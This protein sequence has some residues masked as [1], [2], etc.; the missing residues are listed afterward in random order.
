M[1]PHVPAILLAAGRSR[2]MGCCKQL[3][4]L[5]DRPVIAHC[6]SSIIPAGIPEIIVVLGTRHE[7]LAAVVRDFPA[8]IVCNPDPEGDMSS[9]VQ[10]GMQALLFPATG[11]I[12]C[13]TDH[14]LVSPA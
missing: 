10:V 14:P 12:V 7:E 11:V 8:T 2:R 9:S 6:L 13:L 3:L 1:Q 4:P 5:G